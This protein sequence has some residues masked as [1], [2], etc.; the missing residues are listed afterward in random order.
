[1]KV[2]TVIIRPSPRGLSREELLSCY[3][4]PCG[5]VA[6]L[7]FGTGNLNDYAYVDFVTPE[8]A[9]KAVK[10]LNGEKFNGNVCCSAA[11]T[12]VT[13]TLI[14]K[15]LADAKQTVSKR[16]RIEVMPTTLDAGSFGTYKVVDDI[17]VY[18]I[19]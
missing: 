13:I 12:P 18:A 4:D 6:S 17:L 9:K 11:L 2:Y 7:R 5:K 14:E 3:L 10:R 8:G 1:M 19:S 15:S 16:P